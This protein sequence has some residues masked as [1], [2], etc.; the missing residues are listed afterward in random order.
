[1]AF[2]DNEPGWCA[3]ATKPHPGLW[4]VPNKQKSGEKHLAGDAK[5]TPYDQK[6]M[7]HRLPGFPVERQN[8]KGMQ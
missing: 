7:A 1:V 3:T 8:W 2:A 4:E 5:S 6:P